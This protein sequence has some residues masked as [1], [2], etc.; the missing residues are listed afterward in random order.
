[1]TPWKISILSKEISRIPLT[2]PKGARLNPDVQNVWKY[3]KNNLR[4]LFSLTK[5]ITHAAGYMTKQK[6]IDN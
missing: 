6:I 1:M 5:V 4:S 2:F 3:V